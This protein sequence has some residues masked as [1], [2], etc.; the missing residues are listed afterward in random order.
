M[1]TKETRGRE[2]KTQ[3]NCIRKKEKK[4]EGFDFLWLTCFLE[5]I[6]QC[7]YYFIFALENVSEFSGE[8]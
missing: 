6:K 1:Q 8:D 3:I 5:I 7:F 2:R 4:N